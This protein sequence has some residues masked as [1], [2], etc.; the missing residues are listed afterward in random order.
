MKSLLIFI[1]LAVTLQCNAQEISPK[2]QKFIKGFV[3]AVKSH[4]VNKVLRFMDKTYKKEQLAFLG[5]NKEQFVNELFGGTDIL[6]DQW[7]NIQLKNILKIEIAEVIALKDGSYTYIFRIWD[8]EH[9]ILTSLLLL[10][11]KKMGIE[12]AWG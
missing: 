2:Q 3:E 8:S 5:G 12:G 11:N 6:T 1:A 9:D 7:V 10:K 4:K